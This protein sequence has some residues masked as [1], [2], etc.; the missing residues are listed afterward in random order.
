VFPGA[1]LAKAESGIMVSTDVATDDPVDELLFPVAAIVACAA[2]RTALL[3]AELVELALL[4]VALVPAVERAS[5]TTLLESDTT[6]FD[7]DMPLL[8]ADAAADDSEGVT[9]GVCATEATVTPVAVPALTEPALSWVVADPLG[10]PPE[11]LTQI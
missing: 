2:V 11:V 1:Y 5:G 9:G 8:A 4:V 6:L 3:A 7:I 10:W